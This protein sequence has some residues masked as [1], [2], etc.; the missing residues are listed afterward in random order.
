MTCLFSVRYV[1]YLCI[2]HR[3]SKRRLE[4]KSSHFL[5]ILPFIYLLSIDYL[6]IALIPK[7]KAFVKS[8]K[9]RK[10]APPSFLAN[11]L[12]PHE[13]YIQT[14]NESNS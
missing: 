12:K 10:L 9:N 8:M 5:L 11:S 3:I 14:F 7:N 4:F 2:I 1:L 13:T 6:Y